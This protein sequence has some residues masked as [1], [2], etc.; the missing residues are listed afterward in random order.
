MDADG[1]GPEVEAMMVG[2]SEVGG[3]GRRGQKREWGMARGGKEGI[4]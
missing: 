4:G 1:G 2:A 3:E